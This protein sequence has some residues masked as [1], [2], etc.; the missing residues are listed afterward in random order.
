MMCEEGPP[1]LNINDWQW[2]VHQAETGVVWTPA[3]DYEVR[4]YMDG[5]II[6]RSAAL[7]CGSTTKRVE[8]RAE[9]LMI[10]ARRRFG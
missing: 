7:I 2:S 10:E 8:M 5:Q 6:A 9:A 1:W 3:M 4:R